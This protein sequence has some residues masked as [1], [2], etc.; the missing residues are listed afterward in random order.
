MRK[1]E[2][3]VND[4]IKDT[5]T[6]DRFRILWI[7]KQLGYCYLINIDDEKPTPFRYR[8][9]NVIEELLNEQFIYVEDN[10]LSWRLARKGINEKD[11]QLRNN[12]WDTIKDIVKVEPDI[13][14]KHKRGKLI[15][16]VEETGV[17]TKK[18]ILKY[19]RKY[20]Q[21]G[22]VINCLLPDYVNC[23]NRGDYDYKKKTGRP[24]NRGGGIN[25]TDKLSELFKK[26]I[27]KHYLNKKKP[28]LSFAYNMMLK[29]KF[30]KGYI[31]DEN[32]KKRLRL[33]DEENIPTYAQFYYWF[34]K[35]YKQDVITKKREGDSAYERNHREMLGSTEFDSF[36]P[37][38]LYQIDATPADIYL[39]NRISTNW[40]VGK[41]TLY[42][43]IDVFSRMITGFYI[44]LNNASWIS[45]ASALKNAFSEKK[46]YCRN[47][48]ID[49]SEDQWPVKGLPS[50]IIGDRGELESKFADGLVYGVGVEIN[51]NPPYRPDWKGIVE[52]LFHSSHEG[53]RP[54]LPG[55][56]HKDSKGR[57]SKDFRT[58]ATLTLD[59]YI[60]VIV[61][62]INYYNHNHYMKDYIR[63]PEMIAEDVRP[64]PIQLWN[65]G[66]RTNG[67]LRTL[68][69]K[70]VNF[71]LLPSD[72]ATITAEGI[73][74]KDMLYSCEVA[75]KEGWFAKARKKKWKVDFSYDPR[76]MDYIYLHSS[77]ETIYHTCTLLDHQQRYRNKSIDEIDQF[78]VIEKDMKNS[79][80]HEKLENQ[81]NLFLD[82]EE[83]VKKANKRKKE[84]HDS[85]ISKSK[86][87]NQVKAVK[88]EEINERNTEDAIVL[89]SSTVQNTIEDPVNENLSGTV[90]YSIIELFKKQREK[91]SNGK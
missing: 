76:N 67:A 18:T 2:I 34:K 63:S 77:N 30:N 20:W 74:Y 26:Y 31:F 58:E 57:G 11:E 10:F 65:W 52:Q 37:G 53:I 23:G 88:L 75:L 73:R 72:K 24:R 42:F 33:E 14:E 85:S 81:L 55:Y 68:N 36:G 44:S 21:R 49:I 71:H 4:V 40:M 46:E 45:M 91:K 48:G 83:V 51:N 54:L 19:L 64:I 15:N 13:Y 80:K 12:A 9:D 6:N 3:V 61:Y 8:L 59:D 38:W 7:D 69:E 47:L 90:S 89:D 66:I 39:L 35:M 16:Q 25:I 41:P 78:I 60:K 5:Q 82:V 1:P 70:V 79:F 62:F 87:L 32:G 56:L 43:V 50:A 84:E 29:E 22:M 28:S 17:A 27:N 86:K